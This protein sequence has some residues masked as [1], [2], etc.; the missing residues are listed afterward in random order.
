MGQSTGKAT[1]FESAVCC[2]R[3]SWNNLNT[4]EARQDRAPIPPTVT[5][6]SIKSLDDQ[7][8]EVSNT[9]SM[10]SMNK[11]V[12]FQ[13]PTGQKEDT[14]LSIPRDKDGDASRS[15]DRGRDRSPSDRD[16]R[17]KKERDRMP[18]MDESNKQVVAQLRE[19]ANAIECQ[20]TKFPTSGGGILGFS[21]AC[22][23]AVLPFDEMEGTISF[24][25]QT[26]GLSW[27]RQLG[28]WRRGMLGYWHTKEG[29][30][31]QEEPAGAVHLMSVSK[32]EWDPM[33]PYDV[34]VRHKDKETG[35]TH[36]LILQFPAEDRACEWRDTLHQIRSLLQQT[37]MHS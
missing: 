4:P 13:V 11:R 16:G 28:L 34:F 37:V 26:Q 5:D 1:M 17:R 2:R 10:Q 23:V 30:Q 9:A 27:N 21:R 33:T 24:K 29:F 8:D 3:S 19:L 20:C 6:G 7:Q 22:Y 15:R 18:K 35:S 36:E 14:R 12:T 32:V 25:E 31:Q